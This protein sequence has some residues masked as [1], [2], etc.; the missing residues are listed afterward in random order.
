MLLFDLYNDIQTSLDIP[1]DIKNMSI[2]QINNLFFYNN[3]D[4]D[5]SGKRLTSTGI[6][7]FKILYN[8]YDI[9]MD[10]NLNGKSIIILATML[11]NPWGCE[12]KKLYLLDKNIVAEIKLKSSFS[13]FIKSEKT[14]KYY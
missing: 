1:I 10:M 5:I 9:D 2:K 7:F 4:N 12:N 6:N 14:K 3:F 13:N 11:K 8:L